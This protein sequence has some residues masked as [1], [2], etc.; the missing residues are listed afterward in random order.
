MKRIWDDLNPTFLFILTCALI[1]KNAKTEINVNMLIIKSNNC[2]TPTG[3]SLNSVSTSTKE[4]QIKSKTV[5][6]ETFVLSLTI[7]NRFLFFS[8]KNLEK[9]KFFTSTSFKLSGVLTQLIMKEASVLMLIMFK[10]LDGIRNN[11]RK[12]YRRIANSGLK[13][14]MIWNNMMMEVANTVLIATIVMDGRNLN[15][16]LLYIK[17]NSVI[18]SPEENAIKKIVHTTTRHRKSG[19]PLNLYW[20][21]FPGY[22]MT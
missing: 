3:I 6:M 10:I 4:T 2:T 1:L 19:F 14:E 16:I 17:P 22:P 7:R 13:I 12:F 5:N 8:W 9:T 11:N 20:R 18:I 21:I 15:I